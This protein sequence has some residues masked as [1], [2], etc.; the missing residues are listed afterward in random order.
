[1]CILIFAEKSP[2]MKTI[3]INLSCG[4]WVNYWIDITK[5]ASEIDIFIQ[6]CSVELFLNARTHSV[7][8]THVLNS[9]AVGKPFI[10]EWTV[11]CILKIFWKISKTSDRWLPLY[12]K[13]LCSRERETK[14]SAVQRWDIFMFAKT[15]KIKALFKAKVLVTQIWPSQHNGTGEPWGSFART[16]L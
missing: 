13:G 9:P 12:C 10:T 14:N 8:M 11:P 1:M 2:L 6:L 3:M 7:T 5:G 16:V 15:D 4:K